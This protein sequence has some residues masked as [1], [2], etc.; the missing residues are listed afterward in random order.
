M[1]CGIGNHGRCLAIP[2]DP[3]ADDAQQFRRPSSAHSAAIECGDHL[4]RPPP[5]AHLNQ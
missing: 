3:F 4:F 1:L 5:F 2:D